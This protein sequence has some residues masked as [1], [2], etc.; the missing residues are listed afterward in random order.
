MQIYNKTYFDRAAPML[1]LT[2][3]LVVIVSAAPTLAFAQQAQNATQNTTQGFGGPPSGPLTAI[4]HVFDDPT[5]RV[6][7]FCK[8][9]DKIM[10]VCQLYDSNSPNATLI[11]VE[12]MITTDAYNKNLPDREKP[13]WHYHKE[14][15]APNR[16][17]P[18]LPQLS[19]QQQNDTLKKLAES[20]G[21]VIITWNPNDKAPVFPP[22]V[23]QVQH[24]FIVNTTVTPE[25][26]TQSGTFSQTLKY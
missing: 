4:R 6:W 3:L 16:A 22:Q 24:P 15:F 10:M 25:R 1:I 7:H 19:E 12:Y 8:P 26:E 14:E 5:L 17:N 11:G 9:N 23:E 21:K 2:T 18:K 13:N 20:Y